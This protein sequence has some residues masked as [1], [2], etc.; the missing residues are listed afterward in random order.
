MRPA[1]C[2][3]ATAESGFLNGIR[4]PVAGGL[5]QP[6]AISRVLSLGNQADG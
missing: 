2:W 6:L 1:I 4:L 5:N 3:L